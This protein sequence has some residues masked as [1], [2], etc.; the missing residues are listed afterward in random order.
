[1]DGGMLGL[2]RACVADEQL[3]ARVL[4]TPLS[5][6][7]SVA[8]AAGLARA[9]RRPI[10][11]FASG[12]GLVEGLAGLRE[13]ARL[14]WRTGAAE[15]LPLLMV[16]PSGP[17][18]G[19]GADAVDGID[20]MLARVPGLRV[21]CAGQPS[22]ADAWLRAAADF[23]G[24]EAPTVLLLPRRTLLAEVDGSRPELGRTA[25]AAAR[26]RDGAAATVFT[27]GE[28]VDVALAAVAQADID[29][30][31]VDVGCLAP[32]DTDG[33]VTE[34]KATGKIVIA[35]AG[36]AAGGLGGELAA[37]FAD[38]AILHLDA[39]ITRVTGAAGPLG[40]A[41]EA[42]AVPSVSSIAD[43]LVRVARY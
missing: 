1:M 24:G 37:L 14:G 8:H 9:G 10:L 15:G 5:P 40:H 35:H 16:A 12:L 7:T 29:A 33:L 22:E 27:W 32:L 3:R 36:P 43:A 11:V 26:V 19:L 20:A 31:V 42:R 38:A 41:D 2:S 6:S 39:P 17:G 25:T 30:A 18:F 34:A 23:D 13:A 21:L 4:A 28:T